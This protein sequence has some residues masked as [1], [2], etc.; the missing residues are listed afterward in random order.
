MAARKLRPYQVE[1]TRAAI[2]TTQLIKRLQDHALG[3]QKIDN[4]EI[5]AIAILLKNVI[6]DL[7]CAEVTHD[8]TESYVDAIRK[9]HERRQSSRLHTELVVEQPDDISH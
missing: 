2:R 1:Q 6:P 4:S 5:K 7:S 8:T 9:I 3:I